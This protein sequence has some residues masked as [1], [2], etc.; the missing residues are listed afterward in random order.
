MH[1]KQV[2]FRAIFVLILASSLVVFGANYL[3]KSVFY[4]K[5]F[6]DHVEN[7]DGI[8][9]GNSKSDVVFKMGPP[10]SCNSAKH[11][12]LFS[13]PVIDPS[14]PRELLPL[15]LGYTEPT[16]MRCAWGT[17][18]LNITFSSGGKVESIY[19]KISMFSES[20]PTTTEELIGIFGEPRIY[21]VSADLLSRLY[22][23][24]DNDLQTG[25]TYHYEGNHL[26]GLGLGAIKWRGIFD[27]T[28]VVDGTQYC[29]GATCPWTQNSLKTE[30]KNKTVRYLQQSHKNQN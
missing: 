30:W 24:S 18:N 16:A 21:A 13:A 10:V 23:Y 20:L 22:T 9:I 14:I 19:V 29:P 1:V 8:A 4:K 12:N 15:S 11:S 5:L 28:Y 2:S 26:A 6:S 17:D 25:I 7:I 27:E 3:P